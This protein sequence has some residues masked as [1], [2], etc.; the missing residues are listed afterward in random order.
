M[1]EKTEIAFRDLISALQ[2]ARLYP[3]WHPQFKKSTDKAY[4]SL[5]DALAEREA[6]VIGIVGDELAFEK[7]IFFELSKLARPTILYLKDRGIER[8][9]FL[10]G[11]ESDELSKFIAFLATPKDEI[12]QNV[13]ES[14]P[15]L[16]VRNISVGRIKASAS[17]DL[18]ERVEG[19]IDY[20]GSY[21]ETAGKLIHSFETILKGEELDHLDLR[22][23]VNNVMENLLSR[24]QEFLNLATLKR[25]DERTFFHALDVSIL[26]MYFA[27]KLGFAKDEVL[28]IGV[29]A[30]F[31]D[32]GK[33]NISRKIIRKP[34]GL[35]EK[36]FSEIK[37][38]VLEGTKILL[39]YVDELGILPVVICFEHHL[40]F[41]LSGY[42]K[43]SFY[44]KPHIASMIV[45]ICDNYDA[46]SQRRSYKN[47]YPPKMIYELMIRQRGST[48]E[49]QLIERFFRIIGVWPV[50]SIV[51]LSDARIAV[52][53]EVNEDDIFFPKVEV[54]GKLGQKEYVDL[55]Q[56]KQSCQIE[57]YL[58]P[59]KEG[60][61]YLLYI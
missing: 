52:V 33:I 56:A 10:R 26:S 1:L 47:D 54:I 36:E 30:L 42:P 45:S 2:V 34:V 46:L 14:L 48:F 8:I 57:A 50:G 6:L 19:S 53:R 23:T 60:K 51:R 5:K 13:Q 39:Q 9:Q 40:K 16:G 17:A 37:S 25:Y 12:K 27:S 11:V 55:R 21:E 18:K 35:T 15:L 44:K 58:N 24:Y 29:A 32:I 59:L 43:V 28:E 49:P 20:L 41:D 4:I 3:N 61:D 31:H 22:I 7:E 38:H